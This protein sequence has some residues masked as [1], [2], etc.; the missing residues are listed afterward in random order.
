MSTQSPINLKSFP[1]I[2]L[3]SSL[4]FIIGAVL[5]YL[6]ASEPE[7]M[8]YQIGGI[9]LNLI[10]G[11]FPLLAGIVVLVYAFASNSPLNLLL[12]DDKISIKSRKKEI[13]LLKEEISAVRVRDA[14]KSKVWFL[15]LFVTY[16]FV[17][18]GVECALYFSANHN[19]GLMELII[20]PISMIWIAGLILILFP[21]KLIIILTKEKA[22]IQKV[23]HLPKDES[24]EILV[25]DV[26][27]QKAVSQTNFIKSKMYLYRLILGIIFI[28]LLIITSFLV[29]IGG[30]VQ[31]LHDLGIFIPQ[32][33]L[34]FGVLMVS[35]ALSS[36]MKQA[37]EINNNVLRI[38]EKTLISRIT[39]KNFSWIKAKEKIEKDKIIKPGFR[40]L[41]KFD[42]MMI[43]VVF[44]QG[45]YLAFKI[46]WMPL[47]FINYIDVVDILI[48]ILMLIV[49]FFYEFEILNKINIEVDSEFSFP[50]ELITPIQLERGSYINNFRNLFKTDFKQ[51][52][53]KVG[54]ASIAVLLIITLSLGYLG[55]ALFI[56]I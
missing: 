49:L 27:N 5:A 45:F 34:L 39:G 41:T 1:L 6:I 52:A 47:V 46:I 12:K 24:F 11:I 32:F 19:T 35:S 25:D 22:I 50:R 37:L 21:R 26:F 7:F 40:S 17:Y 4:L 8:L 48:G 9:E 14:G 43:F 13:S 53:S 31:P 56:F 29:E 55:F 3:I 16:Y 23:N 44:G 42:I 2:K 15:F 20:I 54:I 36:G 51:Q 33:L 10:L 30:I 38:E 28:G 18:L